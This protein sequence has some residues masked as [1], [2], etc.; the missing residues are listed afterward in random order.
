MIGLGIDFDTGDLYFDGDGNLVTVTGARAVQEHAVQRVKTFEGE[1]FLDITAG[2][3]WWQRILGQQ[4]DEA[5]A[6]AIVKAEVFGTQGVTEIT[7]FS[8]NFDRMARVINIRDIT[9]ATEYD[10]QEAA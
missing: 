5:L 6:E 4:F 8:V 7:S 10:D 3:P 1:W 2:L 9:V